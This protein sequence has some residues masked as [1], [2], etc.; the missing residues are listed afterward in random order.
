MLLAKITTALTSAA[1]QE[2]TKDE[3]ALEYFEDINKVKKI[4]QTG[5]K[6]M[7]DVLSLTGGQLVV[8]AGRPS[9]GKTT[10]MLNIALRQAS[11]HKVGFASLEMST[12]EIYDRMVCM[13]GNL[14]SDQIKNKLLNVDNIREQVSTIME[15][16]IVITDDIYT[17]SKIEAFIAKNQLDICYVDYLGLI[18]HGDSRMNIVA[19]LTEITMYLKAIAKRYN[20]HI[21]IG[22]QL[23]RGV[24]G[25][26]DKRPVLSDLRDSGSIEQDADIVL[27]LH[28]EEYYDHTTEN[29]NKIDVL[30][31]KNRN[32]PREEVVLDTKFDSYRIMDIT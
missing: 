19:K 12:F 15:K 24:E 11:K 27:M 21:V 5:Y 26:P 1:T 32:G 13:I 23:S 14:N 31:R 22:A 10:F 7:D 2:K 20:C 18:Q 25:R 8:I 30:I 4:I 17:L 3:Q 9:M 28:R 29:K 6:V 16:D